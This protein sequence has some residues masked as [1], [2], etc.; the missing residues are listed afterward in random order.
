[1][2]QVSWAQEIDD[3]FRDRDVSEWIDHSLDYLFLE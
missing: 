2:A 3:W 1:M